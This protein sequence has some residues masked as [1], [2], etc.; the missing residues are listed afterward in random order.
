MEINKYWTNKGYGSGFGDL[1]NQISYDYI[2]ASEP[3][4]INWHLQP[5]THRQVKRILNFFKPNDLITHEFKTFTQTDE[6]PLSQHPHD[7]W[8]AKEIHQGGD[9]VA[10]WLYTQHKSK[11]PHHQEKVVDITSLEMM[12]RSLKANGHKIVIVPSL[13]PNRTIYNIEYNFDRYGYMLT[14]VLKNCKFLICSE[15][16]IAHLARMMRVPSLVY[17][18]QKAPW[19]G[20]PGPDLREFWITEYS[21]PID[22]LTRA[23][24][25][26]AKLNV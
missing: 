13:G 16:G 15:G 20:Q 26:G 25:E 22:T 19:K 9:Y 18:N 1:I 8:L 5:R 23:A 2:S 6:P 17:F 14:S 3:T 10:I 24:A 4:I 7:Y 21:R 12:I 11:S